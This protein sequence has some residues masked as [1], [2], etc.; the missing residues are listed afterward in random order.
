MK[1]SF[2]IVDRVL[3]AGFNRLGG[4][5]AR[6]P[7]Y[8]IIVPILL[9]A[10]FITGFQQLQ[11]ES[12][13]EYL[14]APTNGQAG[15]DRDIIE[16]LFPVNYT[17]KF[18]PLRITRAGRFGRVII[19][20]Q[21]GGSLLRKVVWDEIDLL[22]Q[23]VKNI[24]VTF[25]EDEYGWEK[26][27]AT[28]GDQ[29]WTD[30]ILGI[31]EII[32]EVEQSETHLVYPVMLNPVTFETY[33]LPMFFGGLDVNENS[34]VDSAAALQLHY[35]I[36]AQDR[37]QDI[38][39]I[40]WEEA[41]HELLEKTEFK[42]IRVS[43][44]SSKTL[45]YELE[46]NTNF[47][48]PYFAVTYFIM[49]TFAVITCAEFDWVRAKPLIGLC[50]VISATMGT[51]AS[52]GLL[53]YLG[54]DF[55]GINLAAPFLML[56]I[57]MDDTFVVLA[58]WRRTVK[59]KSVPERLSK[60]YE[61]S[62]VSITITSFTNVISFFI[63]AITPFPSVRIF[64]I[65]SGLAVCFTYLWH[66]TFF[67]GCLALAGYAEEKN[68]HSVWGV[69]VQPKSKSEKKN[70]LYRIFMSGGIS[71]DDPDNPKDNKENAAMVFFRDVLAP[72]LNRPA[73]KVSVIVIFLVYLG[74]AIFGVTQL[75]EGLEKH[76]LA[77]YDSYSIEFY[78][79]ENRFFREYPYKLQLVIAGEMEYSSPKVQEE[80]ENLILRIENS[81]FVGG[82]SDSWLRSFLGYIDRNKD[83]LDLD[84]STEEKFVKIL[85]EHYL[86]GS[87]N[88]FALDV[89]FTENGG[90]IKGSRFLIQTVD[91]AG[92]NDEKD[93]VAELRRFCAESNLNATIYHPY[94]VFF[95]QFLVV[96]STSIQTILV[97][98]AIMTVISLIFIPNPFCA[99]WVAL[100]IVSIET[101]V[102]GYMTWWDVSLDSISMINL[103]MCIGFS[104]DFSAHISYA[105][106]S[107]NVETS[108]ERV[109]ECLHSLGLPIV[110][111]AF[112]TILGVIALTFAPSYIFV[113]FFKTILLVI[114]FGFLHGLFLL[115]VLL[116][117]F[118]PDSC[119]K[120]KNEPVESGVQV[121]SIESNSKLEKNNEDIKRP[122]AI[123]LEKDERSEKDL[124]IGTSS[125]KSSESSLSKK[126]GEKVKNYD[127]IPP[128]YNNEGYVSD[129][130]C[131]SESRW[132]NWNNIEANPRIPSQMGIRQKRRYRSSYHPKI[133]RTEVL[134]GSNTPDLR[135]PQRF[136]GPVDSW[137]STSFNRS[138]PLLLS[139]NFYPLRS[140]Q[141]SV[142]DPI[143]SMQET[144]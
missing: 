37:K 25:D 65:Y 87:N 57:G 67:G 36:R 33:I 82:F 138:E 139:L 41:F 110:Q 64:S 77:K 58:A 93:M 59:L 40:M 69:K 12:D 45:E 70:V 38:R 124:G 128:D 75:N 123:L 1:C 22:D 117:L 130:D 3:A 55:I 49:I 109:Q 83:Y 141:K 144:S 133:E 81:T 73:M 104:V 116:S 113:T 91:L 16:S 112:S 72:L 131:W 108:A 60:T 111:G 48:V 127:S 24:T 11:Y 134:R 20:T 142:T 129:E 99:L 74:G 26:L 84:V 29:C 106:M 136:I 10:V 68:H 2:D 90:G 94:F 8:F 103:I 62:A 92:S 114:S 102:V 47:V 115:P 6:H 15:Y 17:T 88:E 135:E 42:Y 98:G 121:N 46:E 97:A 78:D 105:F 30:T 96:R 63:G 14:F 31:K 76:R 54:L 80:I 53:C 18:H 132:K 9:C 85:K 21:D 5:I 4:I 143:S 95:D 27:C 122:P 107:A 86:T 19:V 28:W 23:L 137:A 140:G 125:E 43:R 34:T 35:F 79:L 126:S 7:G 44:F 51:S 39:G 66:I 119:S 71:P 120:K 56:G 50:G 118:G 101:G 89:A 61:E 13:P 32:A 100:A 52:F